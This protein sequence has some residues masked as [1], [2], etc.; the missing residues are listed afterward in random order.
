[1]SP[2]RTKQIQSPLIHPFVMSAEQDEVLVGKELEHL[3]LLEYLPLGGHIDTAR[4]MR[5]VE[6]LD[7]APDGLRHHDHACAAAEG[8][9]VAF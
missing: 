9:I 2:P 4:L 3:L 5:G 7:C 8:I 6:R 1:M